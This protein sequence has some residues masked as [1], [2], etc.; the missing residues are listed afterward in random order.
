MLYQPCADDDACAEGE[1][2]RCFNGA[3][4][5]EVDDYVDAGKMGR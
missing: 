4:G 1:H 2:G 3:S 5:G